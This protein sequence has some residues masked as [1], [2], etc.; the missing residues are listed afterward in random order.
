MYFY[1]MS[2]FVL[3]EDEVLFGFKMDWWKKLIFYWMYRIVYY[4]EEIKKIKKKDEWEWKKL[5][6]FCSDDVILD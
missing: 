1:W 3:S 5:C 2:F 4:I 6:V